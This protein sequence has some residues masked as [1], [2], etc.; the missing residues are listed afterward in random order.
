MAEVPDGLSKLQTCRAPC[1]PLKCSM[2][3]QLSQVCVVSSTERPAGEGR[4]SYKCHQLEVNLHA[5]LYGGLLLLSCCLVK[6]KSQFTVV[7][8]LLSTHLA[9]HLNLPF[10]EAH[11][12]GLYQ[13]SA[14]RPRMTRTFERRC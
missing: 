5:H 12:R 3:A 6:D 14:Q 1:N 13:K 9:L 10:S 4:L 2:S 11:A 7:V 8:K